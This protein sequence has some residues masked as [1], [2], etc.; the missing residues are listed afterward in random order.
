ME[1]DR[2][3]QKQIRNL[4]L[5]AAVLILVIRYSKEIFSAAVFLLGILKPFIYGAIIAFILNIPMRALEKKVFRKWKGKGARPV[6]LLLS[7]LLI[8]LIVAVIV[9][10][11]IPQLALSIAEIGRKI[12]VFLERLQA[13]LER[14]GSNNTFLPKQTDAMQVSEIQ[15]D[16]V[17]EEITNFLQNGVGDI[18]SSTVTVVGSIISAVVDGVIAFVFAIYIL[19]QKE[20]LTNQMQRVMQAYLPERLVGQINRVCSLLYTNFNNFITGQ[21]LEAVILGTLFAVSMRILR[22]PY[23]LVIGIVIALTALIPIAGAFIG[24]IVGVFLILIEDPVKAVVFLILFVVL[25]QIE[26]KLIYP[27]VVGN[28][29]G[30]PG[31]WVLFAITVGGSLF[32]I[33]GMLVFIPLTATAYALLREDVNKRN[34]LR[35]EQKRKEKGDLQNE[36]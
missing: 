11:V 16:K 7:I 25:Q 29:V 27:K 28:F 18:L 22:I 35:E 14:L 36:I 30:L 6:S 34:A 3:K 24:C 8:V 26:G 12:P 31:I 1:P 4:M 33:I 5:I 13:E 9:G 2:E 10:M 32:G 23:A 15:W 17:M 20:K 21:C 19:A